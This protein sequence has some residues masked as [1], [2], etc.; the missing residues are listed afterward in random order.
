MTDNAQ[1]SAYDALTRVAKPGQTVFFRSSFSSDSPEQSGV[2]R[3]LHLDGM[4]IDTDSG[5]E[6][7]P[8][9]D[10]H[11][12]RVPKQCSPHLHPPQEASSVPSLPTSERPSSSSPSEEIQPASV[13][14]Q[15]QASLL[16]SAALPAPADLELLFAGDPV[17]L[18][19]APSFNFPS[20]PKDIQ[21][22]INRWKN[23]Y[24]YAQK[25]REPARM[26]QDAARIAELA[27][28]LDEPSLYFLAGLVAIRFS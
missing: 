20:L 3:E 16:V 18:L 5:T 12:W 28:T 14:S 1:K 11:V 6:W 19:P 23:R 24:D 27:D 21:Q 2:L 22:D 9:R 17:L 26:S 8:A 25:V 4:V 15:E 7:I 13:V 10:I